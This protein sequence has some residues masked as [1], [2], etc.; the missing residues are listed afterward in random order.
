MFYLTMHPK[1]FIYGYMEG[2]RE[3]FFYITMHSNILFMVIWNEGGKEMFYLTMHPKHF[4][5]GYME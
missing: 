1:H 5:Y 4:I 3:F 2:R